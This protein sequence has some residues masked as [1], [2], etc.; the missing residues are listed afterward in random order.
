MHFP[1]L[2]TGE[3]LAEEQWGDEQR[4]MDDGFS[5]SMGGWATIASRSAC[6]PCR[7]P[8]IV[9]RPPMFSSLVVSSRSWWLVTAS[10]RARSGIPVWPYRE[11]IPGQ[12]RSGHLSSDI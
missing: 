4:T 5:S 1:F 7:L 10:R 12:F 2:C 6:V 3:P 8:S 11:A 9:R